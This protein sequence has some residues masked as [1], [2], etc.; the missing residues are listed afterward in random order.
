MTKQ[1][2]L[3]DYKIINNESSTIRRLFKIPKPL[4]RKCI[5]FYIL[6]DKPNPSTGTKHSLELHVHVLPLPRERAQKHLYVDKENNY[7]GITYNYKTQT[8]Q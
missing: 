8:T 4:L 6:H 2:L 5:I 3:Q 1:D 7:S